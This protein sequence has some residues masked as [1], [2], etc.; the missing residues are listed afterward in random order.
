[1][2]CSSWGWGCANSGR[3][4]T[5]LGLTDDDL[6]PDVQANLAKAREFAESFQKQYQVQKQQQA[7][8]QA[9][10]QAFQEAAALARNVSLCSRV[11]V[12]S[13]SFELSKADVIKVCMHE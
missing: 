5:E 12:G 4:R 3:T 1:L 11:Y 10:M 13:I 7:V 9:Q 8:Q 6:P 2:D